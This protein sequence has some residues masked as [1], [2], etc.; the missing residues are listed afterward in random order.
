MSSKSRGNSILESL[1]SNDLKALTRDLES[2]TLAKNVT[3][4]EADK[5]NEF[6]YFP[7]DAVISFIG[8][9]GP[10]RGIEVWAVGRE[11]AAGISAI[12]GGVN[13]FSGIVLVPGTAL[14]A[15]AETVQ[16]QFHDGGRFH[17]ELLW[18]YQYLLIQISYL[19][20]CNNSHPLVQRFSR[21]LLTMQERTGTNELKVTQDAIANMLGTRRATISVAAAT[22]RSAG[23]IGYTPGSISIKSRVG[24]QKS[25]CGCYKVIGSRFKETK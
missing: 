16:R 19:G 18:Y 14:K 9:T 4:F 1:P 12:L 13:P 2:V 11:G 15:R 3:L 8:D 17:D 5:R 23:F 20:I 22:L 7:V 6:L 25:A 10:R 24:L 21:W